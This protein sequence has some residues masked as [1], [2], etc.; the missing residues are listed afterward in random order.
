MNA[1]STPN[2]ERRFALDRLPWVAGAAALV[3]Y[4]ATLNRWVTFDNLALVSRVN[5]WDWQPA[6]SQPLLLLLTSPFRLLPASWIPLALNGFTAVCAALTLLTLARTVALLPYDRLPQQRELIP[7]PRA[8]L[9]APQAWAPIVLAALALGL[10]LTFWE[11]AISA[12]GEMLDLLMFACVIRCL[13]EHRFDARP[14]WLD[15]AAFL[16]GVALAN[17]WAMA[18]FLPIF[19]V[20]LVR[21]KQF[22]FFRL[23]TL[24]RLDQISRRSI[25]PM[26][27]ADLRFLLRM[28]LLG[29]AGLSLFLLPPLVQALSPVSGMGFGPAL[30]EAVMA[31]QFPLRL[32]YR[33]F[34]RFHREMALLLAVGSLLPV[35]LLSIRW[36][37]LGGGLGRIRFDPVM[38]ILYLAHAF[39]LLLC[40]WIVCGPSC[41]PR[42]IA[43]HYNVRLPFLTFYYLTALSI[44]YYSGFFLVFFGPVMRARLARQQTFRRVLYQGISLAVMVLPGLLLAA[45]LLVNIPVLRA[46]LAPHLDRYVRL[47]AG[48]LPPEGAVVFSEDPIHLKLLSAVWGR[49]GVAN[50]YL[51]VD[52]RSLPLQAYRDWLSR[53]YPGRWPASPASAQLLPDYNVPL[54]ALRQV[55][56]LARVAQSNRLCCLPPSFGPLLNYFYP[57][58]HGLLHEMKLFPRNLLS[59]PPLTAEELASGQAFWQQ[60]IPAAVK[61]VLQLV[62]TNELP[63]SGFSRWLLKMAR[64]QTPPP[65]NARLLAGWYSR[66]LNY[67]GV[68]L[69]RN[70]Q[71]QAATP[72]FELARDLNPDNVPA[73]IN[74]QCNHNLRARQPLTIAD[75]TS[76]EEQ[77]GKY[78]NIVQ[79]LADNGPFDEP[80]ACFKLGL[81]FAHAGLLRQ[82]CQQFERVTQLA[83]DF[84]P[85]RLLLADVCA[86]GLSPGWALQWV[87]EIKANP[88]WQPLGLT[89]EVTLALTEAKVWFAVTNRPKAHGII[90]ALLATH[91][92]NPFVYDRALAAFMSQGS[93]AE[94]LRV[95]DQRL[96][97][98]P[99]DANSLS[100]QGALYL[101]MHQF[102]NAI[103]AL[104]RAL[105]LTNRYA[106]RRSLA[107]AYL[108]TGQLEA[109]EAECNALLKTF[110][111]AYS[112]YSGLAEIALQRKD[113]NT[114]IHYYE[115][116]LAAAQA[117]GDET[118]HIT[119][120]LKLL[121]PG[122]R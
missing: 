6:L 86:E 30:K 68:E 50:R 1:E 46:S 63:R 14:A 24:Q 13:L 106:T 54:N 34:F 26:L 43:Y 93:Y 51:P 117:R 36:G 15:R 114:A 121:Q 85:A 12:S 71:E 21:T 42:Q 102:S 78:R 76:L 108:R 31:Y 105:S 10:Q 81:E 59:A 113:T 107:L 70:G 18:G 8:L 39:L 48:S 101:L 62:S 95:I 27:F 88:A 83:P 52:A 119:E 104:T 80:N 3:V 90:H 116:H 4:L 97:R 5:G 77:F 17:N 41:S 23:R 99:L 98:D 66:A 92:N 16:F 22:S 61:P 20:A 120:M 28:M 64:L 2:P 84:L 75:D 72:C 32:V 60:A 112:T 45:L 65:V 110:P 79:L 87:T 89:N 115:R 56:L 91:P 100:D 73:R 111:D 38:A 29:L 7:D 44:G 94:A 9:T 11:H 57:Q 53:K 96:Q 19:G 35:L 69:Q 58:S 25:K 55:Q 74:L 67:W 118:R 37:R 49:E 33:V 103:P 82:S 109:A 47:A 122:R 40:L